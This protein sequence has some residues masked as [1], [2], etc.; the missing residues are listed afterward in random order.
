MAVEKG[1]FVNKALGLINKMQVTGNAKD[2]ADLVSEIQRM[3]K[4]ELLLKDVMRT[5]EVGVKILDQVSRNG[6]LKGEF[7]QGESV[8]VAPVSLSDAC[9]QLIHKKEGDL[10]K[11]SK[12]HP[13]P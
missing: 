7:Y 9:Q 3:H 6:T 10:A 13:K 12:I 8:G 11:F 2:I 1:M 5:D 4:S